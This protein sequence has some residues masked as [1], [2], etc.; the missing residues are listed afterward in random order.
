M[1]S[2]WSVP[3]F[4]MIHYNALVLLIR[5]KLNTDFISLNTVGFDMHKKMLAN[6]AM[7]DRFSSRKTFDIPCIICKSMHTTSVSETDL[8]GLRCQ[9]QVS[10]TKTSNYMLQYL[11]DV[12]TFLCR[13]YLLLAHKSLYQL[14]HI[15]PV[16]Y[17]TIGC[18]NMRKIYYLQMNMV[19]QLVTTRRIYDNWLFTQ[20]VCE[21]VNSTSESRPPS[22]LH[23]EDPLIQ[24]LFKSMISG[25]WVTYRSP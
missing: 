19:K 20:E 21:F 25:C 23:D 6:D 17:Q 16:G 13:W 1:L 11:Q 9:R 4:Y 2:F 12:Y 15:E 22:T 3:P 24:V 8:S 18:I 5:N 10:W 7:L 14:A